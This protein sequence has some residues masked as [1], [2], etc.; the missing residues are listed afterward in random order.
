MQ[1]E[2]GVGRRL[3][4]SEFLLHEEGAYHTDLRGHGCGITA[5]DF[6]I[7]GLGGVNFSLS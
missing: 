7:L 3:R 4:V 1:R 2:R 5:R 6:L